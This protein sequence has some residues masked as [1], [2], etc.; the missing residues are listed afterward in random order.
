MDQCNYC[1]LDNSNYQL[2]KRPPYL[3]ILAGCDGFLCIYIDIFI[4]K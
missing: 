3:D 2:Y 1:S 4:I